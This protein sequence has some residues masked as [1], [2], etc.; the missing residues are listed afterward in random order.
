MDDIH[1][2]EA[3]YDNRFEIGWKGRGLFSVTHHL[4]CE[5][6]YQYHWAFINVPSDF[7][8]SVSWFVMDKEGETKLRGYE[9]ILV[10]DKL[11]K[12]LAIRTALKMIWPFKPERVYPRYRTDKIIEEVRALQA[13]GLL[14][15]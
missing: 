7:T 2:M 15:G 4:A 6:R 9:N 3:R 12:F 13:S 14:L 11:G 5:T 10:P 1:E 8:G